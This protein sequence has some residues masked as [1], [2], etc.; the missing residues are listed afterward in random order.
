MTYCMNTE[1][2]P[3]K[4]LVVTFK[5]TLLTFKPPPNPP[6]LGRPRRFPLRRTGGH[7]AHLLLLEEV[8][9]AGAEALGLRDGPEG[10]QLVSR[11]DRASSVFFFAEEGELLFVLGGGWFW[12]VG[13]GVVWGVM[14]GQ[15]LLL[16]IMLVAWWAVLRFQEA[17]RFLEQAKL[18][19][20]CWNPVV[21][22][23]K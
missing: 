11:G 20:E 9:G 23:I 6:R 5:N 10:P 3:F 21:W 17:W 7:W 19:M 1:S 16:V 13:F 18:L 8:H 14:F 4:T 12:G 22:G 15:S 2:S